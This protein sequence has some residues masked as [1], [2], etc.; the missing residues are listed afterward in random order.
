MNFFVNT[1]MQC[2]K[3]IVRTRYLLLRVCL[4]FIIIVGMQVQLA[5]TVQIRQ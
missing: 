5:V 4:T 1:A 3:L 2:Y